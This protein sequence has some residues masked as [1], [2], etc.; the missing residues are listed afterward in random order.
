MVTECSSKLGLS[1]TSEECDHDYFTEAKNFFRHKHSNRMGVYCDIMFVDMQCCPL[2][3][4]AEFKKS[5]LRF[6]KIVA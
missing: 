1:R 4:F 2:E 6:L 3:I 5:N